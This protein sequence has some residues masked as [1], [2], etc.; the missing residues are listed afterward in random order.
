MR[1]K[2]ADKKDSFTSSEGV[3]TPVG[4]KTP[5]QIE[6]EREFLLSIPVYFRNPKIEKFCNLVALH[7]KNATDAY[8]KAFPDSKAA[9]KTI[10]EAASRLARRPEVL[11][12]IQQLRAPV[13]A[14]GALNFNELCKLLMEVSN[15][16][17]EKTQSA[18]VKAIEIGFKLLGINLDNSFNVGVNEGGSSV[19]LSFSKKDEAL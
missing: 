3:K 11:Q 7:G 12:R 10:W 18:R 6:F 17:R 14:Q 1:L 16:R 13:I 5:L 2:M 15:D 4:F 19:V 9:V 8:K